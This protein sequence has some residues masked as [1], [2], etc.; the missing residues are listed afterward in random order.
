MYAVRSR[1]NYS[2][3]SDLF[4]L[5]RMLAVDSGLGSTRGET[6]TCVGVLR[7]FFESGLAQA[8]SP[9]VC[10]PQSQPHQQ[11]VRYYRSS[12]SV[13]RSMKTS[14]ASVVVSNTETDNLGAD[15]ASNERSELSL[16]NVSP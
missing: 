3:P 7:Q 8:G 6:G 16:I 10:C 15:V 5:R 14:W 1:R 2:R 4:A 9:I 11:D 13:R 12:Q